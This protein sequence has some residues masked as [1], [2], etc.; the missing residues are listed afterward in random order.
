MLT[1]LGKVPLLELSVQPAPLPPKPDKG[2]A[3]WQNSAA[4]DGGA[5]VSLRSGKRE[6]AGPLLDQ[7]SAGAAQDAAVGR[8]L[9]ERR[10]HI[11]ATP[12]PVT[13]AR[14]KLPLPVKPATTGAVYSRGKG[15]KAAGARVERAVLQRQRI[16]QAK[17]AGSDVGGPGIS[18]GS[19]QE[20]RAVTGRADAELISTVADDAVEH[21]I[22][23]RRN[24]LVCANW[25]F[26]PMVWCRRWSW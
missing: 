19:A 22:P 1:T 11:H 14:A 26:K 5:G 20:H 6:H 21:D 3:S 12:C 9:A 10:D 15:D 24:S 17:L 8:V 7:A 16:G 18:I 23:G 2:A 13:V 4:D 25:M